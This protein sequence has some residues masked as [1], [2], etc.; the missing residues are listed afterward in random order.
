M[1]NQF[2]IS[3]FQFPL[4]R[5]GLVAIAL[6]VVVGSL[7]AQEDACLNRTVTVSVFNAE[8]EPVRSLDA[9]HFRGKIQGGNSEITSAKYDGS[10]HRLLFLVD[11]SAAMTRDQAKWRS[12]LAMAE[13]L[14]SWMPA[15]APVALLTFA[16]PKPEKIDFSQGR[17]AVNTALAGLEASSGAGPGGTAENG[18]SDAM[19]QALAMLGEPHP[20]DVICLIADMSGDWSPAQKNDAE[21][22][23]LAGG[24][25]LFG[26]LPESA[27]ATGG[28]AATDSIGAAA[29]RDLIEATGGDYLIFSSTPNQSAAAGATD[30][31]PQDR[32]KLL[33][34]SRSFAQEMTESY[35]LHIKL[36]HLAEGGS[37]WTLEAL[38]DA[39]AKDAHW[40]V[41][42]PKR[43][44]KCP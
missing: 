9:A 15:Q 33:V 37:E 28:A 20:G 24:V 1:K 22:K 34:A 3:S 31:T 41:I 35:I 26:F 6:T 18:L 4:A 43:L 10:P 2:P 13:G 25:R 8:D 7:P 38:G 39:K 12:E 11:A 27:L 44:A 17:E 30:L 16:N 40:R 21:Q 19:T 32:N 5:L 14:I 29:L 42:Y 23:M 36:P